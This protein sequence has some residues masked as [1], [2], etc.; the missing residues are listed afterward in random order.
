MDEFLAYRFPNEEIHVFQGSWN[1]VD[2]ENS[3]TNDSHFVVSDA[4][5]KEF[6]K[7]TSDKPCFFTDLIIENCSTDV[8]YEM[9]HIDYLNAL[10]G[11]VN[12]MR[13]GNVKKV[14][15]S[16]VIRIPFNLNGVSS[17]FEKLEKE[18]PNA[19]VYC[20]FS[21]KLGLWM[22]ATPETLLAMNNAKYKTM[23]LAG[24][25]PA[26]ST[27]EWTN[28]EY[29]EQQ[30]VTDYIS[31]TIEKYTA[32]VVRSEVYDKYAGPVRH[33]CNDFTFDIQTNQLV[34]FIHDLHPTPAVCG[35]PL[36]ESRALY[37]KWERHDRKLY[38]GVIGLVGRE[39]LNLFVNLRCMECFNNSVDL[40]VGGGIT[41]DSD[42]ESEWN[43]TVKKSTTLSK[44]ILNE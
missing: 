10:D 32:K 34:D 29:Q 15:Y 7:F 43:E 3:L 36:L 11:L 16:R 31:S 13:V 5:G 20:F 6:Y 25:L 39:K 24:T 17:L 2:I 9:S 44:H 1:E 28:K 21:I 37:R 26:D 12:D 40:F 23:A 42:P 41:I 14:V 18:Y 8:Q 22:G 4:D 38:T 27:L 33:L 35:I 30:Y 19:L